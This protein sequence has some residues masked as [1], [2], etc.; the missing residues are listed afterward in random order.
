MER[1]NEFPE[2]QPA[3]LVAVHDALHNTINR[4]ADWVGERKR[5]IAAV[6]VVGG[7]ALSGCATGVGTEGAPGTSGTTLTTGTA[8]A[9]ACPGTYPIV[10]AN[11]GDTNRYY[12]EGVPAIKNAQA[13]S[14]PDAENGVNVWFNL[15][16][17]DPELL[18]GT[19]NALLN[20]NVT[21]AELQ[22]AEGK[23][24][25]PRAQALS[26]QLKASVIRTGDQAPQVG[27]VPADGRNTGTASDGTVVVSGQ[28]GISGDRKGIR[29]NIDTKDGS[30]TFYILARCGNIVLPP[31]ANVPLP[32]GPTDQ[33]PFVPSIPLKHDDGRLPGNPNVPADQDHGTP[34]KPGVGPAGQTPNPDGYLPQEPKPTAAPTTVYVAPTTSPNSTPA[35]TGPQPTNTQPPVRVTA[36]ST[37][38]PQT[39]MPGQP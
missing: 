9:E 34:D 26:T 11:A 14:S 13:G 35:S 20:V 32:E 38:Q 7:L 37:T 16:E 17:A 12:A 5:D 28:N 1:A 2:S 10:Q 24:A 33:P 27:D 6:T 3:V 36:P 21:P 39:G 31:T 22:D 8:P 23:C 19:A 25:T 15:I 30:K 4:V 29:V 18:A